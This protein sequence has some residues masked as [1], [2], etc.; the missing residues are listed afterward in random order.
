MS[1]PNEVVFSGP[2]TSTNVTFCTAAAVPYPA[3]T[4]PAPPV[5]S[6]TVFFT[7]ML[8]PD[9]ICTPVLPDAVMVHPSTTPW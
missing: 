4:I 3:T 7:V 5:V 1:V 9:M 8:L 2:L 6:I